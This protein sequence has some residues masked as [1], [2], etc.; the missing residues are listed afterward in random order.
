MVPITSTAHLDFGRLGWIIGFLPTKC[1]LYKRIANGLVPCYLDTKKSGRRP[2]IR[3][4]S[5]GEIDAL[6]KPV[7]CHD[8]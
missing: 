1:L 4:I 8:A 7:V 5:D 3:R 2:E 6:K